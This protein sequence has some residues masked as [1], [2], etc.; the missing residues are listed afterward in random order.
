VN[1]VP[2]HSDGVSRRL[3]VHV[4]LRVCACMCICA[5][6]RAGS[7]MYLPCCV[8]GSLHNSFARSN[9]PV[10]PSGMFACFH[11]HVC[12]SG[13]LPHSLTHTLLS[14]VL[15]G[16]VW[17][18]A[19]R[20]PTTAHPGMMVPS[21]VRIGIGNAEDMLP[22]LPACISCLHSLLPAFSLLPPPPSPQICIHRRRACRSTTISPSDSA[23]SQSC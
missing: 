16:Q 12:L 11:S 5:L 10:R 9:P 22:C 20:G 18:G 14:Q 3:Y 19:T 13:G 6:V 15:Q 7:C 4:H 8:F 2:L 21:I 17:P 23:R 1:P